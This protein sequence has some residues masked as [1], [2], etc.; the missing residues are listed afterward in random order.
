MDLVSREQG[1]TPPTTNLFHRVRG[2]YMKQVSAPSHISEY[3]EHTRQDQS[4][5]V[6]NLDQRRHIFEQITLMNRMT[7]FLPPEKMGLVYH[8]YSTVD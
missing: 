8:D 4:E 7:T 6:R 1:E 2:S 5:M 3:V